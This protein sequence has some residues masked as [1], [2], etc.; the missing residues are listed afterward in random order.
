MKWRVSPDAMA[1]TGSSS[2]S[3]R[4]RR[5]SDAELR[6]SSETTLVEIRELI[7]KHEARASARRDQKLEEGEEQKEGRRRGGWEQLGRSSEQ[8]PSGEIESE[9]IRRASN[10]AVKQVLNGAKLA[11]SDDEEEPATEAVEAEEQ[12]NEDEEDDGR[13]GH[14]CKL[15][16][17][18]MQEEEDAQLQRRAYLR[19][20]FESAHA[21]F[22]SA[23][24]E[25]CRFGHLQWADM[26]INKHSFSMPDPSASSTA[27]Y[28][29]PRSS[30]TESSPLAK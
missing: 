17:C 11:V 6:E 30:C 19:P 15:E 12:A 3:S 16:P 9:F 8:Q 14:V 2:S 28:P 10:V 18:Y 22:C 13:N 20:T 27:A 1:P 7:D 24:S 21:R 5:I 29:Q 23:A 26:N 4:S 25:S